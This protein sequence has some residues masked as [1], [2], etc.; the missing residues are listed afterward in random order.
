MSPISEAFYGADTDAENGDS[1]AL[2]DSPVTVCADQTIVNY[3]ESQQV[4]QTSCPLLW[5]QTCVVF[6]KYICIDNHYICKYH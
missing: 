5:F 2:Y 3:M 4:R 1:N 6:A